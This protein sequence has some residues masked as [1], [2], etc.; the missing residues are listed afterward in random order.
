MMKQ[1]LIAPA[2]LGATLMSG[3]T[4]APVR[5]APTDEIVREI[6]ALRA[7]IRE[8]AGTSLRA[9]L[10]AA[11]LQVEEQRIAGLARELGETQEQIRALESARNPFL[12]Q[13]LTKLN[14]QPPDSDQA[15]PLAG[16]KA[17]LEKFEHGDPVLKER[18]ERLSQQLSEEQARWSAYN[19]QLEAL[20]QRAAATQ[21][22]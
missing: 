13:M 19:A 12:T 15:N 10:L 20:E 16:L 1:I 17:Q 3:Q 8:M 22:R 6:R 2:V 5:Q 14:E 18:Q 11:R 4:T 9:Q 7:D 21:P